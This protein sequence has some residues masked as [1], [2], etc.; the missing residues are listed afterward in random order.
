MA[1]FAA[2]SPSCIWEKLAFCAF[3]VVALPLMTVMCFS[4]AMAVIA[5]IYYAVMYIVLIAMTAIYYWPATLVIVA[6][7]YLLGANDRG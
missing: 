6:T 1:P 2:T 7:C 4:L 3:S 5:L